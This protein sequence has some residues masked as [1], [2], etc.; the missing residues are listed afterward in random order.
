MYTNVVIVAERGRERE[1]EGGHFHEISSFFTRPPP[2]RLKGST[3]QCPLKE[4][5]LW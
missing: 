3:L 2:S 4:R 5:V 1:G